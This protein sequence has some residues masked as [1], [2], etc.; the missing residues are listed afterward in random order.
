MTDRRTHHRTCNLCEAM[1]G[2][3][4]E[5]EN[6]E[7]AS[8]RGDAADPLSRGHICPKGAALGALH[9]DPDRLRYPLRRTRGGGFA[10][11]SWDE[12][13]DEAATRIHAIQDEHGRSAMAVYAG[14]PTVHNLGALLYGPLLLRGLRTK[15]RFSASSVDQWPTMFASY[16]MYGHQLLWS[17]PDV[18]RTQTFLMLGANPVASGGSFMSGGDM[19]VRL[20]DIVARGGRLIVVDPRRTETAAIASEHLFIRPGTDALFLAALLHE[21]LERGGLRPGHIASLLRGQER[22][23]EA[24]RRF[25]PERAAGPTGID[26]DVIRRLAGE[27]LSSEAA[28]VYGR[29]GTSTQ[30]FGAT[31][32]WLINCLNIVTGNLDRVGGA[33]FTEPAFDLVHPPPSIDFGR[34]S[35]GR[36]RSSVRA[37]PEFGGEL[38][39]AALA[40]EILDADPG[41]AIRGLVTSA[42]NPVL[43]TPNGRRVDEALQSL[44]FLLCIDPYVN[45]TTRHADLILPPASPLERSHYDVAFNLLAV[46]NVAKWSPALFSPSGDTRPEHRIIAGL[47]R[48]LSRARGE[49]ALDAAKW[50]ALEE[51]GPDRILDLGLRLGPR[52]LRQGRK[53][54]SVRRLSR[55]KHGLDLGPLQPCLGSR[56]PAEHAYVDVAPEILVEDLTR[57]DDELPASSASSSSPES[58]PTTFRLIGRRHPRGNNSWMHN[59]PKLAAGK[60]LC[61]LLMHPADATA[62]GLADR[63]EAEVAT[64]IGAVTVPVEFSES[65]MRGVVSLP[66]GFGHGRSGV[67]L[68]VASQRPGVSMN[69]LTDP[70]NLDAL[71]GNAVLT[72]FLVDI[73]PAR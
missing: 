59:V 71:S 64:Q 73:R 49:G 50:R 6:G 69:D 45:E 25:T 27:L 53:G 13:L 56:L 61:T 72:G 1:C 46:R 40:E 16:F 31:C 21:I 43:S 8:I 44:D 38:P 57:L 18:D 20:R 63:D 11:V 62:V 67:K 19:T 24:L 17:V 26:A 2:L 60:P 70:A 48:H 28:V 29:L 55:E 10:R 54:L 32:Q 34:G 33:M 52:G 66:H 47:L 3:A 39:V 9:D 30:R 5:V 14:N 36:W 35:F 41:D 12:A 68:R 15:N 58:A 7:V 65:M 51:L 37:L 42:G 23:P 22:L 4:I